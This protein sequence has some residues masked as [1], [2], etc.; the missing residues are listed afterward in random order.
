MGDTISRLEAGCLVLRD[1]F[2]WGRSSVWGVVVLRFSAFWGAQPGVGVSSGGIAAGGGVGGGWWDG[3]AWGGCGDRGAGWEGD[4]VVVDG[5]G[6]GL[7]GEG[8]GWL[9]GITE[10]VG[11][12]IATL[13]GAPATG[14]CG[15]FLAAGSSG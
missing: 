6:V 8:G 5:E 9:G 1:I 14:R 2:S 4:G 12:S 15:G 10:G 7:L 11:V 3:A 13:T